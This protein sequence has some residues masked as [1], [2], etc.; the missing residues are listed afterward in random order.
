MG[1]LRLLLFNTC[2]C[3]FQSAFEVIVSIA[4]PSFTT[5]L[6]VAM[7]FF[8]PSSQTTSTWI[9]KGFFNAVV[10]SSIMFPICRDWAFTAGV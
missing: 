5:D 7:F 6:H 2:I 9:E 10:C 4:V 3:C 1:T 8:A